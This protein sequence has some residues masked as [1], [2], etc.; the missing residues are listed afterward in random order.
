MSACR[1]Y[2]RGMS[3]I[4]CRKPGARK[5]ASAKR[6]VAVARKASGKECAAVAAL[7]SPERDECG[8]PHGSVRHE[9][10]ANK[11]SRPHRLRLHRERQ[12]PRPLEARRGDDMLRCG[13]RHI[14]LVGALPPEVPPISTRAGRCH[15]RNQSHR[16]HAAIAPALRRR[17]TEINDTG[18][19]CDEGALGCPLVVLAIDG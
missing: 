5:Y 1:K 12:P 19:V 6:R 16:P 9:E 8:A 13:H 15:C 10:R 7:S 18:A 2:S 4:V 3:V 14:E 11:A 17:P